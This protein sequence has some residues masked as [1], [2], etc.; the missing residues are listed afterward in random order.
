MASA[1]RGPVAGEHDGLLYAEL[2]ERGEHLAR[3]PAQR[4]GDAYNGGQPPVDGEIEL[5]IFGGKRVEAFSL[6]LRD[7]AFLVLEDEVRGADKHPLGFSLGQGPNAAYRARHAVGDDI[8]DLGVVLLVRKAAPPGLLDDGV[9]HRVREVLLEAGGK[10]QHLLLALAAEGVY[11]RNA[12][13]GVGERA[14]LVK[15][16]GVRLRG[17]LEELAALDGDVRASGLRPW[18]T[19]RRGAWRA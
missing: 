17:G 18:R 10:A 8:L 13:A 5:R 7:G 9:C 6:F 11:P 15:D 4:V 1:V 14:G 16:D 19:A 12:R 2:P 3:L